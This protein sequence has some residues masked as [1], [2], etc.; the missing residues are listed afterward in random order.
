M[1]EIP[2]R[3]EW[4]E[5]MGQISGFG[6]GDDPDGWRYENCCRAMLK[7][8]LA[9]L[10]QHPDADPQFHSYRNVT[11][12]MVDDNEDAKAL[13]AA[14]VAPAED[15]GGASGAMHQAVCSHLLF[16][17]A[18]GWPAYVEKLRE[19]EARAAAEKS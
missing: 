14:V 3:G 4:T 10:D 12:I 1:G 13:S 15:G 17:K 9:W 7:A 5:D 19:R 6:H 16:I 11:G 2:G 18:N 8:G